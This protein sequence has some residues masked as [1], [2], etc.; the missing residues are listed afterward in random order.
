MSDRDRLRD[1]DIESLR[2][3]ARLEGRPIKTPDFQD[4]Q[5]RLIF[6]D[7]KTGKIVEYDD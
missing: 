4:K 5:G 6:T 1:G 2:R 7:V 3:K